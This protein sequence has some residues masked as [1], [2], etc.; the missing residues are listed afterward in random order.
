[1]EETV[2]SVAGSVSESGSGDAGQ[3]RVV[4]G[5]DATPSAAKAAGAGQPE[6]A[7]GRTKEAQTREEN[8]AF[9]RMRQRVEEL[10]R[11]N[12]AYRAHSEGVA[13]EAAD[14]RSGTSPDQAAA[15]AGMSDGGAAAALS[16]IGGAR[17]TP[18]HT[19]MRQELRRYQRQLL[20]YRQLRDFEEIRAHDPAVTARCIDDLGAE[21]IKLRCA[22]VGNLTAYEAVKRARESG[23]KETPPDTGA[24]G[25]D[26]STEKEYYSP[27]EVDRL[28]GRELDDPKIMERV[29]KSMTKWKK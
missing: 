2:N 17:E 11:Q 12:E 13:D 7:G 26:I 5:Q 8:A 15:P 6:V 29:M 21:Y 27:E 18:E 25:R 9:K 4:D 3:A 1:M 22:G 20:S 23:R 24:V 10:E 19:A 14:G 16:G 28:S